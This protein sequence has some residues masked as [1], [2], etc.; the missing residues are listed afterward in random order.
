MLDH[1][2]A[3]SQNHTWRMHDV[4]KLLDGSKTLEIRSCHMNR[5]QLC[6]HI[7]H[8]NLIYGHVTFGASFEIESDEQWRELLPFHHWDVVKRPYRRTIA[9]RVV[10]A[11]KFD[12]PIPFY[13]RKCSI[14]T[15]IYRDLGP[16]QTVPTDDASENA[17]PEPDQSDWQPQPVCLQSGD[18]NENSGSPEEM[19][20]D[21]CCSDSDS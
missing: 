16:E 2:T 4:R 19:V 20:E 1:I 7:S 12:K 11:T 15:T 3:R 6:W 17:E 8:R 21:S 18:C 14:G 5:R 10:C 13:K 9:H